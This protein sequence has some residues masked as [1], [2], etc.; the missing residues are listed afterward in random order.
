MGFN[1][2]IKIGARGIEDLSCSRFGSKVF[3]DWKHLKLKFYLVG[4]GIQK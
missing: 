2:D 1:I 4:Y 3:T